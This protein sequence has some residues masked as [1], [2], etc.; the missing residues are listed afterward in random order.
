MFLNEKCILSYQQVS[1]TQILA[2]LLLCRGI[3][4][5]YVIPGVLYFQML[6]TEKAEA[7]MEEVDNMIALPDNTSLDRSIKVT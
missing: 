6:L 5:F 7:L 4:V 2:H 1:R 3:C